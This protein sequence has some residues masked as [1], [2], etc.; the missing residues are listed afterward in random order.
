[1]QRK[2][3]VFVLLGTFIILLVVSGFYANYKM[4][5]IVMSLN[6]PGVLFSDIPSPMDTDNGSSLEPLSSEQPN[7]SGD[8]T[9]YPQPSSSSTNNVREP[10]SSSNKVGEDD[11]VNAVKTKINK[12]LEKK[13]LFKAGLIIIR[14]LNW[15]EIEY[16]YDVG[17][18]ESIPPNELKEVHR[19]LRSRLSAEDIQVMQDLGH[20]Y[21][22]NLDFLSADSL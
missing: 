2:A 12:P 21:G 10:A 7:L 15:S 13:D 1:M 11:I 14:K 20:K 19:I 8:N 16:L 5:Q 18:N 3:K 4:N 6:R 9:W 22:K 17:T